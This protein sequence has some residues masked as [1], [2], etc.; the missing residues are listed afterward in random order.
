MKVEFSYREYEKVLR[1]DLSKYELTS[2]KFIPIE[3]EERINVLHKGVVY[4]STLQSSKEL[5]AKDVPK[6]VKELAKKNKYVIFSDKRI[7]GTDKHILTEFDLQPRGKP[8]FWLVVDKQDDKLF[9]FKEYASSSAVQDFIASL[10]VIRI[11]SICNADE[12]SDL[13]KS[14]YR[15]LYSEILGFNLYL[16]AESFEI[17]M[18]VNAVDWNAPFYTY[19]IRKLFGKVI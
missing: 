3:N 8:Y 13:G 15:E 2:P 16:G 9:W 12:V 7:L 14:I 6:T 4:C 11:D 17:L 1:G 18:E 19:N 5:N 10:L